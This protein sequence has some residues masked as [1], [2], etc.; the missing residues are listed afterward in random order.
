MSKRVARDSDSEFSPPAGV[1][2]VRLGGGVVVSEFGVGVYIS[3]LRFG[4]RRHSAPTP[5]SPAGWQE[6]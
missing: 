3:E 4:F 2:G 6:R 5:S 1:S